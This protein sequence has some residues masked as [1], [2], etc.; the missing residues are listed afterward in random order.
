MRKS[1][2]ASCWQQRRC[3]RRARSLPRNYAVK[4]AKDLPGAF[5]KFAEATGRSTAELDKA[6]E[7]GEVRLDDFVK[8]A[9]SLLNE[10]EEDAKKIADGPS[11]AGQRLDKALTKL[12]QSIGPTLA[13]MGASFQNFATEA[14][15]ALDG[16]F[17]RLAELDQRL[18]GLAGPEGATKLLNN[19][20]A[21]RDSLQ[22]LIIDPSTAQD[23]IP[24][25]VENLKIAER[26]VRQA[27]AKLDAFK[28]GPPVPETP[29]TPITPLDEDDPKGSGK[30]KVDNLEERIRLSE[31]ALELAKADLE[32][33][34]Q[35]DDL[36]KIRIEA[37]RD[38]LELQFAVENA[39][40]GETNAIVRRNIDEENRIRIL[41]RQKQ[42][43][44]DLDAAAQDAFTDFFQQDRGLMDAL[45]SAQDEFKDFFQAETELRD[46]MGEAIEQSARRVGSAIEDG[47]VGS[48]NAAI[49][50]AKSLNEVLQET[51]SK[52]FMDIGRI[53]I[54]AGI[55]GLG[56]GFGIPGF[57]DGG[58]IK[59]NSLAVVGENGPELVTTGP[60]PLQVF[61]NQQSQQ[62]VQTAF[63]PS[64][65][66][67]PGN[68]QPINVN[69]QSET[70]AGKEYVTADQFQIGIREAAKQGAQMGEARTMASL[71]NNRSARARIGI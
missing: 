22:Q 33:T 59:P 55:N 15:K 47:I 71:K 61:S 38:I 2:R 17:N 29:T 46:Y 34:E 44:Q 49:T 68:S 23:R 27:Q 25:L 8:F 6:L 50:G 36:E 40:E 26:N 60:S 28:F 56:A 52:L 64:Q 53:F 31:Q 30:T 70:I 35:F 13:S 24:E 5:S 18:S 51:A 20:I 45:K 14:I 37:Y 1:C 12:Q 11:A 4:S 48:L 43:F 16:V 67:V 41:E 9:A 66:Y 69:F 21:W 57:A 19:A 3:S 63:S 10:Y 32:V 7:K 62:A 39:L 58:T 42:M 65:S 54:R